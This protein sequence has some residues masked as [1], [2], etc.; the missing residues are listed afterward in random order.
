M[1]SRHF[2]PG[3]IAVTLAVT[4]FA[5]D[6]SP[7]L[8]VGYKLL[9]EQKFEQPSA[10]QDFVMT[11]AKAW[12]LSKDGNTSAL[13]LVSQSNYK[14]AVR[15]PV[16]IALIADKVFS[17]FILEADL[18]QTGKEYGHRDMCLFFGFQD[19]TKFYYAHIATAADDHAHNIFIV[20]EKPRTKIA[21]ETT[22][23]VNWGLGIWHKVRL[24]RKVSDGTVKVYF[25]D[26]SKPIMVAEDKTFGSGYVGFG[27]FDDTGKIANIKVWGAVMDTRK[28]GFFSRASD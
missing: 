8:P 28:I 9:Y 10:L 24:E 19:P 27:S 17:D 5:A 1:F 21:T 11:D 15:S 3:I 25:D 26:F 12:K 7:A 4:G 14:P 16:N 6:H 13:E 22:K 20:N 23:G 18:I 2:L